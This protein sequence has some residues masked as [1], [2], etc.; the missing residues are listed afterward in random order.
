MGARIY[1]FEIFDKMQDEKNNKEA[2]MPEI[3]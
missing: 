2:F 3:C 1:N